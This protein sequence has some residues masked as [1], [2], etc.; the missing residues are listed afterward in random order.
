MWIALIKASRM[1]RSGS[2]LHLIVTM[3]LKSVFLNFILSRWFWRTRKPASCHTLGRGETGKHRSVHWRTSR[4]SLPASPVHYPLNTHVN[5]QV[6]DAYLSTYA[7]KDFSDRASR[8]DN[9]WV[10]TSLSLKFLQSIHIV[11]K[12]QPEILPQIGNDTGQLARTTQQ[13]CSTSRN[14]LQYD[15]LHSL[16]HSAQ[17]SKIFQRVVSLNSK[18][19]SFKHQASN[20]SPS[21]NTLYSNAVTF[22]FD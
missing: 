18:A 20:L 17:W 13:P 14:S 19:L 22:L 7:D 9:S 1:L 12:T 10:R 2:G 8:S 11:I 4:G 5:A 15:Q 6:S 16:C 3:R 21:P